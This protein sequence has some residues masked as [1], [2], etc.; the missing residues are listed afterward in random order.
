[1]SRRSNEITP[2]LVLHAYRAGLFPMAE[3]RDAA[4]LHWLD[5]PRRMKPR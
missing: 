2:E 3:D 5:P 4:T 1:M